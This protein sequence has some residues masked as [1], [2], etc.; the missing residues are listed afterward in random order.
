LLTPIVRRRF[1]EQGRFYDTHEAYPGAVRKVAGELDVLL[2]DLHKSTEELLIRFGPETSKNLFLHIDINEYQHLQK[3]I[4]DDTHLSAYGAFK[5][6]DM[7]AAEL[8]VSLAEL[9]AYLKE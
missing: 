2:I 3:P 7:V 1:D 9:A 5:V 4:V 6:A 8:K